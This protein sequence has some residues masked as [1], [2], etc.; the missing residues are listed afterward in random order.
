MSTIEPDIASPPS[1]PPPAE[2]GSPLRPDRLWMLF[3]RPR[4][5][6]E[7]RYPLDHLPS[8]LLVLMCMGIAYASG[9]ME[10]NMM[11]ADLDQASAGWE[12]LAPL[13]TESWL[14][15]WGTMLV[16]GVMGAAWAWYVGGWWYRVRLG[17]AGD[18]EPDR[19]QAR[20]VYSYASLVQALPHVVVLLV[21]T[22]TYESYRAAWE[23]PDL[24]P[25]LGLPFIFLSVWTSYRGVRAS[26]A[27]RTGPAL[28]WFVVLPA[29]L[30]LLTIG[31]IA[32]IYHW[33]APAA[34]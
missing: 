30:Y 6:F 8:L 26:F 3:V 21:Q 1:S 20:L 15:F 10:K 5:F 28:V 16:V 25:T 7:R 24:W 4:R 31:G 11:Q 32:A 19:V 13:L 23:S 17:W 27:V 14:G 22:A 2:T 29:L 34:V 33:L 18:P 12:K 9:R